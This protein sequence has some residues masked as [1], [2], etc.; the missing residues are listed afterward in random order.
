MS[1]LFLFNNT[2]KV[3]N[4]QIVLFKIVIYWEIME[5]KHEIKIHFKKKLHLYFKL[6]LYKY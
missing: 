1:K 2:F 6:M 5:E 4:K 3:K